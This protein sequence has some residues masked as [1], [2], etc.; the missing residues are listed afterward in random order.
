MTGDCG[1]AE[2]HGGQTL[3]T[4]TYSDVDTF[5]TLILSIVVA[6]LHRF[7]VKKKPKRK[8]GRYSQ[9]SRSF[10]TRDDSVQNS[11]TLVQDKGQLHATPHQQSRYAG[12]S[13]KA[14][15]LSNDMAAHNRALWYHDFTQLA[16]LQRQIEK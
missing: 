8:R 6:N 11:Q 9:S 5:L 16:R 13:L 7:L 14:T 3:F 2:L 4:Y 10:E 1:H 12:R 15:D